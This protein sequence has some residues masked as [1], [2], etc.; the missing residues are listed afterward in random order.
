ML[1]VVH[2]LHSIL[3]PEPSPP[4]ISTSVLFSRHMRWTLPYSRTYLKMVFKKRINLEYLLFHTTCPKYYKFIIV[5]TGHYW[6][7]LLHS[8][9]HTKSLKSGFYLI[10]TRYLTLDAK[11]PLEKWS[12]YLNFIKFTIEQVDSH[13][14]AVPIIQSS[15]NNWMVF[16]FTLI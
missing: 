10:L 14:K 6:W 16:K 4:I 5:P 3:A 8:S 1:W 9:F 11:F 13:T 15:S 2:D 12:L 7:D